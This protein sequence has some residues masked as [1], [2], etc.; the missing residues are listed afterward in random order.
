MSE[1][2]QKIHPI[3]NGERIKNN[4]IVS[5]IT[6]F[7]IFLSIDLLKKIKFWITSGIKEVAEGNLGGGVAKPFI[8][9]YPL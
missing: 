7:L 9:C 6:Y 1:I 8:R 2:C 3:G 5:I 4:I